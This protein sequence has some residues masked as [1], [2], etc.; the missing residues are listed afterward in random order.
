M[1]NLSLHSKKIVKDRLFYNRFVHCISFSL[2][3]I[4]CL[5]ELDHQ[6]I[7]RMVA[8]RR[9]WREISQQHNRFL[10]NLT[11]TWRE[12]TDTDLENLHKLC[13]VLLAATVEFK[14]VTSMNRGWVY[15]NDTDFLDKVAEFPAI[16]I[17]G[18]SEAVI[19]RPK[20][21]ISL[22]TP[23]HQYRS[24]FRLLKI[25]QQQKDQ[26][27]NFLVNQKAHIR[28]SPALQLW[29]NQPFNRIQDY[30]FIDH[31]SES[32]LTMLSLVHPGLIR[33]TMEIIPAK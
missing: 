25:S 22:K 14:L 23:K 1:T 2:P 28:I 13:D 8:K 31:D 19:T 18:I 33:K 27:L 17:V 10:T 6:Q 21:T 16:K 5:K 9:S 20:N 32:W 3:E 11:R 7:D 4:S 15:T 12:I 29:V 24:Y 26:L 30:F